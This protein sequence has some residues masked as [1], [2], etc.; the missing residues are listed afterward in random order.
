MAAVAAT[1]AAAPPTTT[2]ILGGT[3]N[4]GKRLVEQ[5]LER[6]QNVKVIVRS[7]ER[8]HQFIPPHSALEVVES[9]ILDTMDEKD[10]ISC[11]SDCDAIVSCLGHNMTFQGMFGEPKRLVVDTMKHVCGAIKTIHENNANLNSSGSSSSSPIR[12]V[13]V[14]LMSSIGVTNPDG[15][16]AIRPLSERMALSIIRA[17]LPPHKDNEEAAA[18]LHD[19]NSMGMEQEQ[20]IIEW[21]AVRP[22]NLIEGHVSSYTVHERP[23]KGLFVGGETTRANVAHFM[24]DLIL[25][26]SLWKKW[27]SQMP[28]PMNDA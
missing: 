12:P 10:L 25:D 13:K 9:S 16:D 5:L 23:Q 11:V 20:G 3:G 7:H 6:G 18:F 26:Q 21:V 28:V 2:L 8:F 14:I 22:D 15:K 24:A 19:L 4:T 1:A 27:M 17:L